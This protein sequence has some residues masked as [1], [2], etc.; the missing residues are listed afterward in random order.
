[1]VVTVALLG[2]G[3]GT[4]NL[5]KGTSNLGKGT[6]SL[7]KGTSNLGKGTSNL[8]CSMAR[9]GVVTMVMGLQLRPGRGLTWS[10]IRQYRA[11]LGVGGLCDACMHA[12]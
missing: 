11:L 9:V 4:S 7:G 2:V 3:K 10:V 5:G 6:S 1:M 8:R 12:P